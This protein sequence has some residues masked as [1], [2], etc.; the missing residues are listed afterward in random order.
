MS[1]DTTP[2]ESHS[3]QTGRAQYISLHAWS[4][5]TTV[6]TAIGLS[7][8]TVA[9]IGIA[10][11][12]GLNS[13]TKPQNN[14]TAATTKFEKHAEGASVTT[15]YSDDNSANDGNSN[16]PKTN[17]TVNN[18]NIAVPENG[19]VSKTIVTDNG[20]TH[21]NVSNSSSANGNSVSSSVTSNNVSMSTNSFTHDVQINNS[22]SP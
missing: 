21:V 2:S 4:K 13:D 9:V 17:V 3:E 10:T 20:T 1:K 18:E 16:Q 19:S 6:I 14:D 8:A 5:R 11:T 7:A 12:H 15:T 22:N